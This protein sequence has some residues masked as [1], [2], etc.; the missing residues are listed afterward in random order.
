MG[1]GG[2][3]AGAPAPP[4]HTVFPRRDS[5]AGSMDAKCFAMASTSSP[6]WRFPWAALC[7]IVGVLQ[8][9]SAGAAETLDPARWEREVLVTAA[10]D[11]VS[12]E[13]VADGRLYFVERMGGFKTWDP[14]TRLTTELAQLPTHVAWDT[15]LLSLLLAR[16]F[17]TS[18]HFYTLRCPEDKHLVMRVSRFTL[19][20]GAV[21]LKSE[22]A[23]LEWAIDT[24]EPPHCGGDLKWDRD[25]NLVIGSGENTPPQDVPAFDPSPGKERFDARRS[26]ANSQDLRGKILRITPQPDGSYTIPPGNM[27]A[28]TKVGRPEV[29]A[30]G[31]RNAF[32]IFADPKTGWIV[33][34]DV[35]GNVDPNLGL[36]PEG[37][38]EIN[39]AKAPGFYGW[40][41]MSGPNAPWRTFDPATKKPTGEPFDPRHVVN[42][43]RGNTGLKELPEAQPALLYYPTVASPIWPELGSGGRSITGGPIYHFDPQ[44]A[45]E[46]KLPQSLD[47]CLIFAEW[48]RNWIK[49]VRLSADG[50]MEALE[51]FMP[52]TVFRK[53]TDLKLGPEGALYVVEYGDKFG[54]NRDGQIVRCVYR[55]GNRAP[56]ARATAAVTA[57][58]LPFTLKATAAASQDAD[59]DALTYKWR[60]PDGGTA[61]GREVEHVFTKAGR[62]LVLVEVTDPAGA[63]SVARLPV[64]A[65]NS[66]P[67][68]RITGPVDGGFFDWKQPLTWD[69]TAQ[70]AE[71]GALAPNAVTVQVERR[72]RL[73]EGDA[74]TGHPGGALMRNGTCFG[75]HA[76]ADKSAGPPYLEVARRYATNA[77]AR[78]I[79]AKKIIS[80]GLGSWGQV[81]MP[82]NPQYTPDQ[83]RQMVDW[84]LGLAA[85][86]VLTQ[87]AGLHGEFR[88]ATALGANERD[89]SGVL[90]W[91]AAATDH[92]QGTV[93]A[94]RGESIVALRTRQQRAAHFDAATKVSSQENLGD[95]LVARVESGGWFRFDRINLEQVRELRL[96]G[97]NLTAG[98]VRLEARLDAP[99]GELWMQGELAGNAAGK[100]VNVNGPAAAKQG[101]RPVYIV[102][103]GAGA[104]YVAELLTV[105]FQ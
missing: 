48:M 8:T 96:R 82:P 28:D 49:V 59:G 20:G 72:D 101:I 32:R 97:R 17:A 60:F 95:G 19:Q 12:V 54:N 63:R 22:K 80:G 75:C 30:M 42:D 79:L 85:R 15:G 4:D 50:K 103:Q 64:V 81:A 88:P 39:L 73:V 67:E 47:G 52:G 14:R 34:G 76:A 9:P 13:V 89:A 21:D 6:V 77:A 33:W 56:V 25:G 41:F 43:S 38:D 105:G 57:G 26:S 104:G 100:L 87:P 37:Y 31:I 1:P 18:G 40:P 36:G 16:D 90:V 93:P 55:R 91:T 27:F 24:E 74:V 62:W 53:P 2:A 5:P 66:P 68:V 99:D 51:S 23:I 94:L 69:V 45:S 44:L 86:Q 35:G 10:N 61:E 11:P 58:R 71:D 83:A 92:A 102:V 46:V 98:A 3:I 7:A 29:F 70:D 84:V 78:E 65:G